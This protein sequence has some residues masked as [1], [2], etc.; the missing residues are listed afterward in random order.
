ML[1]IKI[2]LKS[3]FYKL[4]AFLYFNISFFKSVF[5]LKIYYNNIFFTSKQSKNIKK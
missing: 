5:Y 1:F 2:L 4:K 3:K